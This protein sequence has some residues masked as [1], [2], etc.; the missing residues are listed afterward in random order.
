MSGK[1]GLPMEI[2]K[3]LFRLVSFIQVM[4]FF[5][6][7]LENYNSLDEITYTFDFGGVFES[8]YTEI[9]LNLYTV[10]LTFGILFIVSILASVSIVDSGL[11]D[12]GSSMVA[13]YIF[14]IT[15]FT[16]LS[17]GNSYYILS[18]GLVGVLIEFIFLL[19]WFMYAV[20]NFGGDEI[21]SE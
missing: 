2:V 8:E 6:F 13:K 19:I 15:L 11:N 12:F 9:T 17:I 20:D 18:M 1:G 5:V 14:Y 4:L 16:I 7:I 21:E 3:K 10:F